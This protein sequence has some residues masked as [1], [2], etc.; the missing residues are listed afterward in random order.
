MRLYFLS[1][2]W[3]L[4]LGSW[5]S[6]CTEQPTRG[7]RKVTTPLLIVIDGATDSLLSIDPTQKDLGEFQLFKGSLDTVIIHGRKF[8]RTESDYFMTEN[9]L[10][11]AFEYRTFWMKRFSIHPEPTLIIYF[12]A[13]KGDVIHPKPLDIGFAFVQNSFTPEEYQIVKAAML[14]AITDWE[15]TCHV[16]FNYQEDLD[17]SLKV[18]LTPP[19]LSFTIEKF[20]PKTSTDWYAKAPLPNDELEYRQLL[21]TPVFFSASFSKAGIMRHEIGHILGFLHEHLQQAAPKECPDEAD[22]NYRSLTAYDS[23]SVMH[24]F[25]MVGYGAKEFKITKTDREAAS[26]IY[27]LEERKEECK[28][29]KQYVQRGREY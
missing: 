29:K 19:E 1:A 7:G 10:K 15:Q 13:R 2:I 23:L 3:L 8:Y 21:V 27:C 22:I 18:G 26:C 16:R 24:P 12:D 9:D 14:T 6:A 4:F 5:V 25:C 17:K 11:R 20:V 28:A